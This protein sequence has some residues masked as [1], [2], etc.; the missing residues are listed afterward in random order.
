[1][2]EMERDKKEILRCQDR[3]EKIVVVDVVVVADV[4]GIVVV[5]ADVMGIV[6]VVVMKEHLKLNVES[7][8][9]DMFPLLE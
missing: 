4:M 5:V 8:D 7:R 1:M 6:G 2:D 3:E 9:V